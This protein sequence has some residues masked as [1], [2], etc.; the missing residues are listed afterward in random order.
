[1]RDR[2]QGNNLHTVD[3]VFS[4]Q[5]NHE[6]LKKRKISIDVSKLWKYIVS[7]ILCL[8][9]VWLLVV[10]VFNSGYYVFSY[11]YKTEKYDL[12][13]A[14]QEWKI[15][16]NS[17]T[18]KI[19]RFILR[20]MDACYIDFKDGVSSYEDT[21]G[22]LKTAERFYDSE[23]YK[24]KTEQLNDSRKAYKKAQEYEKESDVYN[25][26][27]QYSKV[28]EEDEN[29]VKA[30][31]EIK[32][33]RANFKNIVVNKL[34]ELLKQESFFEGLKIAYAVEDILVNDKDIKKY[35]EKL[36][37][38]REIASCNLET[39]EGIEKYLELKYP[40][41]KDTPMG[42]IDFSVTVTKNYSRIPGFD[43]NIEVRFSKMFELSTSNT[44]SK[45][46]RIKM[47]TLLRNHMRKM[48]EDIISKIPQKK[49]WGAYDGVYSYHSWCNFANEYGNY[50]ETKATGFRWQSYQR[51]FYE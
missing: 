30:K 46:E 19:E 16:S 50:D 4:N 45:E 48:A 10:M 43:Y 14:A 40:E 39:A 24:N 32:N 11:A 23:T 12:A 1:M 41:L 31:E 28:I 15:N 8:V 27:L 34:E 5:E 18:R 13:K 33:Y 29:C 6:T 22:K 51:N 44:Y 26:V 21:I 47:D 49:F 38:L 42:D 2:E 7:V 25:A 35:V 3:E 37:H 9:V 17:A 20:Q 36:T